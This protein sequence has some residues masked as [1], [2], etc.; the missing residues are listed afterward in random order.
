[1]I[2]VVSLIAYSSRV[3]TLFFLSPLFNRSRIPFLVKLAG[4]LLTCSFL[5]FPHISHNIDV[6]I[7]LFFLIIKEAIIGYVIG[8]IFSLL[9][10]AA[11]LAGEMMGTLFGFSYREFLYPQS[12]ST[13]IMGPLIVFFVVAQFLS[14]DFHH[15][16]LKMLFSFD[17][18][19]NIN[20]L[21]QSLGNFFSYAFLF[22]LIP[23]FLMTFMLILFAIGSF[24]LPEIPLFWLAP[25]LQIIAGIGILI[26][27]L[28][29]FPFLIEKTFRDLYLQL[30]QIIF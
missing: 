20:T 14:F 15:V 27:N 16:I 3:F 24:L 30:Q 11:L 28:S 23:F 10:E 1:M 5:F 6:S 9:F 13:S 17:I 8:F 18:T 29:Q 22:F 2:Q 7:P 26:L 19:L 25:P 4:S 12:L 21:I